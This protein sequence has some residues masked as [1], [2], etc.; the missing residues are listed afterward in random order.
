MLTTLATP[1]AQHAWNYGPWKEIEGF[2]GRQYHTQFGECPLCHFRLVRSR[3]EDNELEVNW[4]SPEDRGYFVEPPCC[5]G[6]IPRDQ[7]AD[8]KAFY[9]FIPFLKTQM[10]R[11]GAQSEEARGAFGILVSLF[12]DTSMREKA[13]RSPWRRLRTAIRRRL[14][15]VKLYFKHLFND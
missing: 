6:G 4:Y 7:E 10:E 13:M 11:H 2:D 15:A 9:S 8:D 14:L 5:P 1:P 12:K 3:G